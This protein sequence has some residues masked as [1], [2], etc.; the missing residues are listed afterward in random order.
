MILSF[1]TKRNLNG[2][3]KFLGIDTDKKVFSRECFSWYGKEDLITELTEKERNNFIL[4]LEKQGFKE[5]ERID[6]M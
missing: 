1:A 5:I 3:R 2:Y 4:R 6:L